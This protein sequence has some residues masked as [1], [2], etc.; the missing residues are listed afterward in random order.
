MKRGFL[1]V[2]A[3]FC[4]CRSAPKAPT[5]GVVLSF[6]SPTDG[7]TFTREDDV[8]E[9]LDGIQVDITVSASG[10]EEGAV[11][12]LD[13]GGTLISV[14]VE[15][16]S[17]R[18]TQITLPVGA[19][20]LIATSG[21]ASASITVT[22]DASGLL[23][24][25]V[26]PRA[27]D[28]LGVADDFDFSREGL[29]ASVFVACD[30]F[31][32]GEALS[33]GVKRRRAQAAR[34]DAN[35]RASIASLDLA[36]GPNTLQIKHP[37]LS[38]VE[39]DVIV[40]TGRCLVALVPEDDT[41]IRYDSATDGLLGTP[42]P[43]RRVSIETTCSLD[44][45]V[46]LTL[47]R[48]RTVCSP[49]LTLTYTAT[50]VALD[51]G[52]SGAAFDVALLT[53]V[54]RVHAS[55]TG[56]RNGRSLDN[57]WTVD[58]MPPRIV[59]ISPANGTT[60]D[61]QDADPSRDGVQLAV[62]VDVL[63]VE[64]ETAA[65]LTVTDTNG[66][67]VTYAAN[68]PAITECFDQETTQ[69][70]L[71]FV[72]D[73]PDGLT[74]LVLSVADAAGNVTSASSSVFLFSTP[75]T[76][77]VTSPSEGAAL[78][79]VDDADPAAPGLQYDVILATTGAVSGSAGVLRI[80]G[81]AP[82]YFTYGATP[83]TVRATFGTDG[84]TTLS[85]TA[86][87]ITGRV[88]M[89]DVVA[90][91]VDATSPFLLVTQPREGDVV[92]SSLTVEA[93]LEVEASDREWRV[94]VDDVLAASATVPGGG[95]L[96]EPL[97]VTQTVS[98][99]A[100]T[101]TL[102]VEVDDPQGNTST[103]TL[104]VYS[105]TLAPTLFWKNADATMDATGAQDD[106]FDLAAVVTVS[107]APG[108]ALVEV[109]LT[110]QTV[111]TPD[112]V[113]ARWQ[114]FVR[115]VPDNG[116]GDLALTLS[117]PA[118]EPLRLWARIVETSARASSWAFLDLTVAPATDT[119]PLRIATL[120]DGDRSSTSPLAVSIVTSSDSKN[121]TLF[122]DTMSAATLTASTQTTASFPP[123]TLA[124]GVHSLLA[125]CDAG[126]GPFYSQR[127]S[128][129]YRA[130]AP[131][132][133]FVDETG[134]KVATAPGFINARAADSSS[135]SGFQHDIR[136][137]VEGRDGDTVTL[138]SVRLSD[139][140]SLGAYAAT[141][142]NGTATFR[143]VR[144]SDDVA[145]AN[146]GVR[147][148]LGWLSATLG[149]ETLVRDVTVDRLAP[150]IAL[151]AGACPASIARFNSFDN[152]ATFAT[153]E[154]RARF[155]TSG[156]ADGA[157]VA[158][159]VTTPAGA[160]DVTAQILSNAATSTLAFSVPQVL[161]PFSA[162][163]A[164]TVTDAAG[165]TSNEALCA[166]QV[167]PTVPV[168]SFRTQRVSFFDP[169]PSDPFTPV[170]LALSLDDEDPART[171]VQASVLVTLLNIAPNATVNLCSTANDPALVLAASCASVPGK[172]LASAQSMQTSEG[173][174]QVV[175]SQVSFVDSGSTPYTLAA[176]ARDGGGKVGT[177]PRQDGSAPRAYPV[178]VD[179]AIP[180]DVTTVTTPENILG[181]D[182]PQT[183]ALGVNVWDG[184]T[185]RAEGAVASQ[186]LRPSQIVFALSAGIA[187]MSATLSSSLQGDIFGPA[188]IGASS[189]TFSPLAL[190]EGVHTLTLVLTSA[191]G[192]IRRVTKTIIVDV[193]AP[194][195][196][197]AQP[198]ADPYTCESPGACLAPLGRNID[199]A[200]GVNDDRSLSGGCVCVR[201][202]P[203]RCLNVAT[204]CSQG[205]TLGGGASAT[206]DLP[207]S[208]Q[209]GTSSVIAEMADAIGNVAI[210]VPVS[211]A[212]DT[213]A[214]IGAPEL[215]VSATAGAC[216]G[217]SVSG[218]ELPFDQG[219]S[220]CRDTGGDPG[221]GVTPACP[222]WYSSGSYRLS[223]QGTQ[224]AA[225]QTTGDDCRYRVR[226][227]GVPLDDSGNV[228]G[229]AREVHLSA[230]TD[231]STDLSNSFIETLAPLGAPGLEHANFW[232]L[233]LEANDRAGN[234]SRSAPR[235]V[236]LPSFAGAIVALARGYDTQSTQVGQEIVTGD[237]LGV[238]HNTTQPAS[239]AAFTTTLQASLAWAWP[240]RP[241]VARCVQLESIESGGATLQT[242]TAQTSASSPDTETLTFSQVSLPVNLSPYRLRVSVFATSVCSG[243]VVGSFEASSLTTTNV[244][245]SV[246]FNRAW[247]EAARFNV[248]SDG[249][250]AA[251]RDVVTAVAAPAAE[252]AAKI[253]DGSTTSGL[254]FGVT[255]PVKLDVANAS[256]GTVTLESNVIG[257]LTSGT[258]TVT[259]GAACDGASSGTCVTFPTSLT[260]PTSVVPGTPA[261]T[262]TQIISARVCSRAGDC[263]S[264]TSTGAPSDTSLRMKVNVDPPQTIADALVC[265]GASV[266]PNPAPSPPDTLSAYVD[267]PACTTLCTNGA[268]DVRSGKAVVRFTTPGVAQSAI[269]RVS[270]YR[271]AVGMLESPA[272]E[273]A[274]N[275]LILGG[276]TDPASLSVPIASYTVGLPGTTQ[277]LSISGVP[278]HQ[279]L[280][281][282]VVA[283][284]DVG[285][286]SAPSSRMRVSLLSP[287][288]A[289]PSPF[290]RVGADRPDDSAVA[291][292]RIST[293]ASGANVLSAINVGD[294]DGDGG[295]EFAVA[296]DQGEVRVYSSKRTRDASSAQRFVPREIITAPPPE[297][298]FSQ[299][300]AGASFIPGEAIAGGDFNGDGFAD[301]AISSST[302]RAPDGTRS[303]TVYVYLGSGDV[304]SADPLL[305][306]RAQCAFASVPSPFCPHVVIYGGNASTDPFFSA[307]GFLGWEV[308]AGHLTQASG[309]DDLVLADP[310]AFD[311]QGGVY[312]IKGG[313]TLFPAVAPTTTQVLD[314]RSPGA[315]SAQ[316]TKLGPFTGCGTD[317]F[318]L[319][320]GL[321]D[322]DAD[323]I[324]DLSVSYGNGIFTGGTCDH[325]AETLF[326]KGG[327]LQATPQRC[328]IAPVSNL[329]SMR[330]VG[331]IDGSSAEW[332]L[333]RTDSRVR[334]W[335]GSSTFF[336]G[337]STCTALAS[338]TDVQP[339]GP[340]RAI[341]AFGASLDDTCNAVGG[342]HVLGSELDVF[343][344]AGS[345]APA[346]DWNGDGL[347]D[348]YISESTPRSRIFVVSY[349][350]TG[351]ATPS[352]PFR[353][354]AEL[355][356]N[357]TSNGEGFG[358]HLFNAGNHAGSGAS[359]LGTAGRVGAGSNDLGVWLLR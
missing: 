170:T 267:D 344:F 7:Q 322:L 121:C 268:C 158:T 198:E 194:S 15:N 205:L 98:V 146:E 275:A 295:A 58:A 112:P 44:S 228:L 345:A 300:F 289:P 209:E 195:V 281:F 106:G 95:A 330:G 113:A 45:E 334:A 180:A 108:P 354:I 310:G 78:T 42:S 302:G 352:T 117:L 35:G 1:C 169:P 262:R 174:S 265:T 332:M 59:S 186:R 41:T 255:R 208:L 24:R 196:L 189:V 296:T 204:L 271:V 39:A 178:R 173:V 236:E 263:V 27:G 314:L 29:Q 23:C 246:V 179:S 240:D 103:Q 13:A 232:R 9:A 85:A 90:F 149:A 154:W 283:T 53:G 84:P 282:A 212:V 280:C 86:T 64:P 61:V 30:G 8:S 258:Q 69:S 34:I 303:G 261:T 293:A 129:E 251:P 163:F 22:A 243:Q 183:L 135:A 62:A 160:N 31:A 52:A 73:A 316:I 285:N 238:R 259:A 147:L 102:R 247:R 145:P 109:L 320:L 70:T 87:L 193:T 349:A 347:P 140:A 231:L 318:E 177:T 126:N 139:S 94:F 57:V 304:A 222:R 74:E 20:L 294:M 305:I 148:T 72:I 192:N 217:F 218:C 134:V 272:S 168:L 215:E 254:Q 224:A 223:T 122:V 141:L 67:A 317:K 120:R 96:H 88:V 118:H 161:A 309:A 184:A 46:T 190:V 188:T 172:V 137:S 284:D 110:D 32:A 104:D 80:S 40:D 201:S 75:Q 359:A 116:A 348:F 274:C 311:E 336:G 89:S 151:E 324:S 299:Q 83:M 2:L 107:A 269:G 167:D 12:T 28:V 81:Q 152:A 14:S 171:G 49:A 230:K 273:D 65:Q 111:S 248:A 307:F 19:S 337:A 181:N 206:P 18:F 76:L 60:L 213:V 315:L 286:V 216:A 21:D 245:P 123:V 162:S 301:L 210:S 234:V 252:G 176:E 333:V 342:T 182:T 219:P 71:T 187:P 119:K 319:S 142:W 221:T 66:D 124:E 266:A 166:T 114:R 308:R 68:A 237:A 340:L 241:I 278:V 358:V 128:I 211:Y 191:S 226:L 353:V 341:E 328:D 5:N 260:I 356:G 321:A 6:V 197:V 298:A 250:G 229:I 16:G 79:M 37:M 131:V 136:V 279:R 264:T 51:N 36:E 55:V 287:V 357:S 207:L 288:G 38:T 150:T 93:Q 11:V 10:A 138:E 43:M 253:V 292:D 239:G 48:P 335:R 143:N 159:Y 355:S 100:G 164:S 26:S 175:F 313:G 343:H 17:A 339:L 290:S 50:V 351:C 101:R 97:F 33:I 214:T 155:T 326:F 329:A 144:L 3:L 99:S 199:V 132:L 220:A 115:T 77:V 127:L 165:N 200:V 4:A 130:S 225:C 277:T 153:I 233:T 25:F 92:S 227:I 257:A 203:S 82:V 323:G 276:T 327:A 185:T 256:G 249:F 325:V 235:Y 63:G 133:A 202:G 125:R 312:V 242:L 156:A 291:F 91:S 338:R 157:T 297:S 350:T 244:L 306:K 56:E 54:Q 331:K 47:V 105:A 346:G 270:G